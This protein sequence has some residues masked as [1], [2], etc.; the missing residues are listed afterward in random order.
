MMAE[1]AIRREKSIALT[2]AKGPVW[3]RGDG[4]MIFR[5]VRNLAENAIKTPRPARPSNSR[6]AMTAV[7]R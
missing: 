7:S 6:L 3:M 4:A 1:I 2:G 5:A